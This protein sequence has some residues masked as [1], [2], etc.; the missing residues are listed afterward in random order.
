ME[1]PGEWY[2]LPVFGFCSP[3]EVKFEL[4]IFSGEL[5]SSFPSGVAKMLTLCNLPKAGRQ[6]QR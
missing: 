3:S 6:S 4:D 5:E 2:N 1:S